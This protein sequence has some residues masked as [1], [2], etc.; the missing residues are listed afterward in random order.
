VYSFTAK[1][2]KDAKDIFQKTNPKSFTAKDAKD[3][4]EYS[5]KSQNE[6]PYR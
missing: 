1:D 6:Q 3:A 4:K 2:T 5:S